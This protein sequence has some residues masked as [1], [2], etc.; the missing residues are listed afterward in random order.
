[1]N[2]REIIIRVSITVL[3]LISLYF[4]EAGFCGGSVVA[5]YNNGFGTLDMKKYSLLSVRNVLSTMGQEGI[6]VYKLYYI[7]DYIFILFF[8][9]FQIMLIHDVYSFN[10]NRLVKA[11]IIGIPI[12]RGLC[13]MIENTILLRTLFTFPKVNESAIAISAFFTQMKLWCIK[14]WGLLL[15]IG[16]IWR[17]ALHFKKYV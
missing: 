4:V 17:L 16:L 10:E 6:M 9:L 5:K 13:D 1:M 11:F 15:C 8:G 14:G 12:L 2:K 3:F 7:M